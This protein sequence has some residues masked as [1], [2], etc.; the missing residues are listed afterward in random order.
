MVH[1]NSNV[2]DSRQSKVE[3]EFDIEIGIPIEIEIQI[4]NEIEIENEN[5][6]EI[7]IFSTLYFIRNIIICR[8][9]DHRSV[10]TAFMSM[11]FSWSNTDI[12]MSKFYFST[13]DIK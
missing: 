6:N 3:V 7:E 12:K 1:I 10:W 8:A 11:L 2:Q 13:L 9:N 5:E 4:E